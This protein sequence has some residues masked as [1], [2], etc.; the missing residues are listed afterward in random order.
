MYILYNIFVIIC[1]TNFNFS[2]H[3]KSYVELI[4]YIYKQNIAIVS[5]VEHYIIL[6]LIF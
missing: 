1:T 2:Y 3:F 6:V 4:F 5:R